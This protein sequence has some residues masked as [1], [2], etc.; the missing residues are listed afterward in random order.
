MAQRGAPDGWDP[1]SIVRVTVESGPRDRAVD[2]RVRRLRTL[3]ATGAI[4]AGV[5]LCAVLIAGG[6]AG[7]RGGPGRSATDPAQ[8]AI[9]PYADQLAAVAEAYRFPLGCVS[10]T[11]SDG[12][13]QAHPGPCWRYGVSVTAILRRVAGVW[14]LALEV[15]S[16][17]CPRVAL[18]A[19]LLGRLA[20]C[21]R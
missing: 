3:I 8:A 1:P 11:E 9:V 14:R 4:G 6:L 15:R 5:V 7:G 13:L 20:V 12:R 16:P 18:P 2:A 17:N 10:L 19:S 21:R